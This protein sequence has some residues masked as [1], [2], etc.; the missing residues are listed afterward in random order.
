MNAKRVVKTN[1]KIAPIVAVVLAIAVIGGATLAYLFGWTDPIVNKFELNKVGVELDEG[2]LT[3]DILPADQDEKDPTVTVRTTTDAYVYILV[4]GYNPSIQADESINALT[5]AIENYWIFLPYDKENGYSDEVL[6][7]FVGWDEVEGLEN[8]TEVAIYYMAVDSTNDG[9]TYGVLVDNIVSYSKYITMD[10][11]FDWTNEDGSSKIY[12]SFQSYI[13]QST[14]FANAYAALVM[15]DDESD[16]LIGVSSANGVTDAKALLDAVQAGYSYIVLES[17]MEVTMTAFAE[18]IFADGENVAETVTIDL[19]GHTLTITSGTT[20]NDVVG[21]DTAI[22]FT[23][24]NVTNGTLVC[25][26]NEDGTPAI[27]GD[28]TVTEYVEVI[29]QNSTKIEED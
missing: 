21:S 14:G 19:N 2:D 27:V 9:Q 10:D 11:I 22:T 7:N 15:E 4:Y 24:V 25:V 18:Y 17:D 1:R 20:E 3:F 16:W 13:I 29:S 28:I 12:L 8:P 26:T 6:A 23:S 5:Y